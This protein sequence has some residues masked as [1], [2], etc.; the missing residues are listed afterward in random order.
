MGLEQQL[1]AARELSGYSQDEVAGALGVSRAMI[2]YWESGKRGP[3]DRQLAALSRLLRVSV[4]DLLGDEPLESRADVA[5]M[6]FRGAEAKLP[7]A[8]LRGLREFEQFLDNY[9]RLADALEVELRG[10]RQSP[11]MT[12]RAYQ[13]QDD[14]RRKAE[15]VRAH[16]R[17]GL[18]PI[19]D[20]D[21]V[22]ELLGITIFRAPLGSDLASTVSGAFFNHPE[23][24]F[25]ILVNLQMTPGR[26]RFTVAHELAHALY[27]SDKER[28]VIS[29]ASKD[30]G[31][32]FADAFAGE[33]LMPTEGI[34]RVMEEQAIGPRVESPA[35]VI[36]LQR[37][38]NVSYITALVRLRQAR[39]VTHGDYERFKTVRPVVFARV[40]GYEVDEEEFEHDPELWRVQRFPQRFL[41]LL[42][43]GVQRGKVSVPTAANMTGLSID[44]V[45][46]L[47]SDRLGDAPEEERQELEQFEAT[48]VP[49]GR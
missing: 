10:L 12:S 22:C 35:D 11:F 3:N 44:E 41:W 15:E 20:V 14:A 5:R 39:L 9:A 38:F 24:G 21:W 31:E 13:S 43:S 27:H 8:A 26:R 45:A 30:P 32:R 47:V 36:H 1:T 33:L 29:L 25:S 42:R 19:G 34:R 46:D 37:F 4:A 23:V 6:L 28:F 16:L 17:L 7:P 48:G 2:S 40:L 49:G 18:G